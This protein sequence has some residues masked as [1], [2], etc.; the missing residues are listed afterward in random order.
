MPLKNYFYGEI[1][2]KSLP[3]DGVGRVATCLFE[4]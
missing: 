4:A 2:S 3:S 1:R